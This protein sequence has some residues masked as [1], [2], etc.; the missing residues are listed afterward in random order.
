MVGTGPF[1]FKEWVPGDH[2]TLV[3]NP[4]YWD[5]ANVAH[6]DQITFLPITDATARLQ[7]LQSGTVDVVQQLAPT[8]VAAAKS[9][10][11][12]LIDR[13]AACNLGYLAFSQMVNGKPSIWTNKD[14]RFAAAYA[15]QKQAYANTFIGPTAVVPDSWADPT[16]IAYKAE[17]LPTYDPVKAKQLLQQS[18]VPAS[19]LT[20]DLYYPSNASRPYM[21]NPEGLAEAI[22]TDLQAVGFTVNLK[23]EDWSGGYLDDAFSGKLPNVRLGVQLRLE[24]RRRLPSDVNLF[25]YLNGKPNPQLRIKE[26]CISED[27]ER[28]DGGTDDSPGKRAVGPGPGHPRGRHAH[29]PV[30]ERGPSGRVQSQGP[31]FRGIRPA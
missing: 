16:A 1:I 20:V 3:K 14:L 21:P 7:A 18:G 29:N 12:V 23:T 9:S 22:S 15:L 27:H 31:R 11:M 6:L 10:G 17:H 2:V 26:R 4:N 25:S 24:R 5:P 8:D 30:G 28:G 19:Q 13:G